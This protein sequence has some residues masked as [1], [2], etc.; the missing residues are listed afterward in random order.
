MFLPWYFCWVPSF[1][2]SLFP[3]QKSSTLLSPFS[4]L[5]VSE[6]WD[7]GEKCDIRIPWDDSSTLL[8]ML[9]RAAQASVLNSGGVPGR[10][11]GRKG[12]PVYPPDQTDPCR[13]SSWQ[14]G[15]PMPVWLPLALLSSCSL[16]PSRCCLVYVC[17]CVVSLELVSKTLGAPGVFSQCSVLI[18]NTWAQPMPNL[19]NNLMLTIHNRKLL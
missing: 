18:M 19:K 4:S 1:L 8:H 17:V 16:A 11:S 5:T 12:A 2:A 14:P 10:L 3:T 6:S 7:L 15:H 13:G 9:G